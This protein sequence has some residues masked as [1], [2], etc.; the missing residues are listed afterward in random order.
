MCVNDAH[1]CTCYAL[2]IGQTERTLLAINDVTWGAFYSA[3]SFGWKSRKLYSP[4]TLLKIQT[5]NSY[6]GPQIINVRWVLDRFSL[7]PGG[8]T[9]KKQSHRKVWKNAMTKI[10]C[11]NNQS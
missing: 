11:R 4:S 10:L 6:Q 2:Q 7:M 8:G 1:T 3:Q 5:L 9:K